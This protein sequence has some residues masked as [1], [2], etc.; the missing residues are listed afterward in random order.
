MYSWL[1]VGVKLVALISTCNPF[2]APLVTPPHPQLGRYEV[3]ATVDP[4]TVVAKQWPIDWKMETL[5]P[6]DAFGAAGAYDRSA[7]ARLYG[8]RRAIVARGWLQENGRFEALTLISP[9]PDA[10]LRALNPGTLIIRYIVVE[11]ERP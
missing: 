6:L 4:L 2:P 8:G 11:P 3:C 1:C 5:D 7:V 10:A 9:H